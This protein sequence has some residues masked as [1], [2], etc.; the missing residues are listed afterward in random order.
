M[1]VLATT[2]GHTKV[3]FRQTLCSYRPHPLSLTMLIPSLVL[4]FLGGGLI[5]ANTSLLSV[6]F[7]DINL[8]RFPLDSTNTKYD[9][10]TPIERALR[11]MAVQIPLVQFLEIPSACEPLI[12]QFGSSDSIDDSVFDKKEWYYSTRNEF[13]RKKHPFIITR[14]ESQSSRTV[15]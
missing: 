9:E 4:V 11:G 3:Q 5:R 12:D 10:T 13:D 6:F 7:S 8:F 1:C 15:N 14:F 2:A